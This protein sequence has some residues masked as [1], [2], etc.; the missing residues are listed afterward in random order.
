ML[1]YNCVWN[2]ITQVILELWVEWY[3]QGN[4]IIMGLNGITVVISE[5]WGEWYMY[6]QGHFAIAGGMM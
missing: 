5:L 1:S 4:I 6:S 3:N 2:D